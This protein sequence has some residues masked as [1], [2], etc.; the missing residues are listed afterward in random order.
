MPFELLF[1]YLLLPTSCDFCKACILTILF[2]TISFLGERPIV[3]LMEGQMLT[4]VI[5]SIVLVP[6]MITFFVKLGRRLDRA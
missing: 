2:I 5:L 4:K 1:S 6:F 3:A